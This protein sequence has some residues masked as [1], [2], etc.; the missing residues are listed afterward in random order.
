MEVDLKDE[1]ETAYVRVVRVDG[2]CFELN[3]LSAHMKVKCKQ[4]MSFLV[5]SV[6]T[7]FFSPPLHIAMLARLFSA[8][9][10]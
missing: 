2:P 3:W 9:I 4:L 6:M 7:E 1:A 10:T 8:S 5:A